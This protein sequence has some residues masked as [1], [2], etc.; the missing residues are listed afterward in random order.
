MDKFLERMFAKERIMS[1]KILAR[2]LTII[3][4]AR[5]HSSC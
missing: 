2:I 3:M 5:I 4:Q 1:F